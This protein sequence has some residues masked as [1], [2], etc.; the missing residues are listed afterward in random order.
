MMFIRIGLI[1][2]WFAVIF[3]CLHVKEA[4]SFSPMPKSSALTSIET[5]LPKLRL[6]VS[7]CAYGFCASSKLREQ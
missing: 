1:G 3:L 7:E 6:R 4:V 2:R 5:E